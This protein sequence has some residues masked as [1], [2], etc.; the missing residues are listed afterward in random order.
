MQKTQ[1]F[2]NTPCNLKMENRK[3]KNYLIENIIE[4]GLGRL[5]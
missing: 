5:V 2:M 4:E 1:F 3:N